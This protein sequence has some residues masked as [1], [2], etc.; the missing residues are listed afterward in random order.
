MAALLDRKTKSV[1]GIPVANLFELAL[2]TGPVIAIPVNATQLIVK[3]PINPNHN[4]ENRRAIYDD[5]VN[6]F[7]QQLNDVNDIKEFYDEALQELNEANIGNFVGDA[8]RN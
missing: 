6:H 3:L 5:N 2:S 8:A 4:N 7:L 1:I